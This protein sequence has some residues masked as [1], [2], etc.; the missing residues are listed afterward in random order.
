M[1]RIVETIP[2]VP[3]KNVEVYHGTPKVFD[4]F[5]TEFKG[6]RTDKKADEVALHFSS[7]KNTAQV[8]SRLIDKVNAF[9]YKLVAD[10]LPTDYEPFTPC[11]ITCRLDIENPM[12]IRTTDDMSKEVLARARKGDYDAVIALNQEEPE[13]GYEYA[14]FDVE[15]ITIVSHKRYEDSEV[16]QLAKEKHKEGL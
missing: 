6:E 9:M 12:F 15:Q 5:S 8:Y 1:R 14:V 16:E 11:V 10:G 7:S 2:K 3:Y 13:I 4:Q